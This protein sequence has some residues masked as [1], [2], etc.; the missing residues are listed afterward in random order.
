M[1]HTN[2]STSPEIVSLDY[3]LYTCFEHENTTRIRPHSVDIRW[4]IGFACSKQEIPDE[5]TSLDLPELLKQACQWYLAKLPELNSSD[6]I[7]LENL[8]DIVP[9]FLLLNKD[10]D[11]VV[12]AKTDDYLPSYEP[13][14]EDPVW[15]AVNA[16][17]NENFPNMAKMYLRFLHWSH[18][19]QPQ[20][21]D[22]EPGNRP[23]VGKYAP[24][25]SGGNMRNDRGG[26][27]NGNQRNDRGDRGGNR[28]QGNS[29]QHGGNRN[30]NKNSN[31]NGNNRNRNNRGGKGRPDKKHDV[32]LERESLK[33]VLI[34]V[35]KLNADTNIGEYRL[36]PANSYYRRLQHKQVEAEGLYSFSDGE[37]NDRAVVVV[38]D[39]PRSKSGNK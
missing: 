35:Q 24:R 14:V 33:E 1:N 4:P 18:A 19:A 37:G 6:P 15:T 2:Q 16:A 10:I 23:P 22:M 28:A 11:T 29:K 8:A 20:E 5:V 27:R 32:Q 39:E 7:N 9:V 17:F 26:N 36:P 25:R 38:R 3:F 30:Q 31:N 13:D 12:K 34:A 21:I